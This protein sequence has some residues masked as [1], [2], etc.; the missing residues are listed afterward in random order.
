M[1]ADAHRLATESVEH[2]LADEMGKRRLDLANLRVELLKWS[3]LFWIG[4][5]AALSA[6]FS[7]LLRAMR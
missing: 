7:L 6:V 2:R 1:F 3:F 5:V 4:Q